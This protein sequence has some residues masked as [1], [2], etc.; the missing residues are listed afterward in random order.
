MSYDSILKNLGQVIYIAGTQWGDEGKGK[1]VDILAEECDIIARATGGAN[2]GHTICTNVGGK[3]KKIIFHLIPSGALHADK[4]CI[5]GN[6]MVVHVPTLLEE[7]EMLREDGIA[8]ENRLLLSDRAHLL[9]DYHQ[10]I[11]A[12]QEQGRGG[13]K[14]GT[15]KRGI[16]PA[17][18]DK[19]SRRGIRLADL[20]N[21]NLFAEKLRANMEWVAKMYHCNLDIEQEIVRYK[22]IAEILS[23]YIVNTTEFIDLA[24]RQGKR[25]LIEGAQGA[26]LDIDLGTY[27]Y[28][29]SSNTSSG[30][31]CIGLGLAPNRLETVIG[32]AKAYTTRV[33][34]GPFPTELPPIEG[35]LLREAGKEYGATTGRPR[36]CGW[37]DVTVVRNAIVTSGISTLNLTKLDVFSGFETIKIG[38]R[39]LLENKPISFIPATVEELRKVDVEYLEMPGWKQDIST[40]EKFKDLPK[41]CQNYVLKLEELLGTPIQFI[42]VGADREQMIV[43]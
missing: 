38:T 41:L 20:K 28:V 42:G 2:A 24:Y 15:T 21:F 8:L 23:P 1:L 32:I 14:V 35:D 37:F 4:I 33:G 25:I 5:I 29:T 6:G 19:I 27:P 11:D 39:Y 26:H 22:D 16:G 17:Y 3:K 9:F 13:N 18:A 36:R 12:I 31:A 40:K 43:R 7:M 34:S 30:G 10:E